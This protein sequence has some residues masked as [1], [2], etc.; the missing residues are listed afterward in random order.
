MLDTQRPPTPPFTYT[1]AVEKVRKAENAWNSQS[2]QNI[3][4]AYTEDSQW[5]NRNEI[6]QGHEAIYEFLQRKFA[7][8]LEYRLVKELWAYGEHR[9]AVRFAYEWHNAEAQWFRSYGNENWEFA[10]CGR[11][12]IRH[13][14]INDLAIA[15]EDRKLL[16][17]DHD[18]RPPDYPGLTEL[19]L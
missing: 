8:E 17:P 7:H 5:R 4:L 15:R 13:A 16:W 6:F 2:A 11:M 12:R 9:I 18:V 3:T 19:G 14:S 10:S 1:S